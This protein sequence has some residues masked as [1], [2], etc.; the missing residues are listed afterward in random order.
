MNRLLAE[1]ILTF[2]GNY[3]PDEWYQAMA[4]LLSLGAPA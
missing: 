4:Y 3:S 1:V 2:P